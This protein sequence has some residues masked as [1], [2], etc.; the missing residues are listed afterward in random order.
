MVTLQDEH[1]LTSPFVQN[2]V[3]KKDN[4]Y[5]ISMKNLLQMDIFNFRD[6]GCLPCLLVTSRM[7]SYSAGSCP[8]SQCLARPSSSSGYFTK[9]KQSINQNIQIDNYYLDFT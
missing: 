2:H 3:G 1:F 8:G 6:S 7:M 5:K 9:H 4:H